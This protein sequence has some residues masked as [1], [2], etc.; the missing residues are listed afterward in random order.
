M[1]RALREIRDARLYRATHGTFEDYCEQRWEIEWR[2]A[3]QLMDA[4]AAAENL[5]ICSGPR[6][7]TEGQLRPLAGLP[8]EQQREVARRGGA[9]GAFASAGGR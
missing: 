6:P 2:R 9:C 1:G 4:S 3:Y 7:A 8:P 5:N